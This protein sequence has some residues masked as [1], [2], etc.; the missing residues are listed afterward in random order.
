MTTANSYYSSMVP[1]LVATAI[2]KMV[3]NT[4]LFDIFHATVKM[5]PAHVRAAIWLAN[6]VPKVTTISGF[7]NLVNWEKETSCRKKLHLLIYFLPPFSKLVYYGKLGRV[8]MYDS[9]K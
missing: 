9:P 6:I 4:F 8:V 1:N 3:T 7:S 5:I 2:V